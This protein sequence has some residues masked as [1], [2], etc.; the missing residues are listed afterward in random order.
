[1]S[2]GRATQK[3]NLHCDLWFEQSKSEVGVGRGE[4]RK[5]EKPRLTSTKR[6]LNNRTAQATANQMGE[7]VVYH[8]S[9]RSESNC[10]HI[11]V[12]EAVI[13]FLDCIELISLKKN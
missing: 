7:S 8:C 2:V 11:G 12:I 10:Q 3:K 4:E 9:E 13:W 6:S 5:G 1:M